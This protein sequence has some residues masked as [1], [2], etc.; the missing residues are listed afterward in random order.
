MR[1]RKPVLLTFFIHG[2]FYC[3][4]SRLKV[5]FMETCT[6]LP[7]FDCLSPGLSGLFICLQK[8]LDNQRCT[9][10]KDVQLCI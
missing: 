10:P 8:S 5:R 7:T 2:R 6:L 1:V 4:Y 9:V 3:V